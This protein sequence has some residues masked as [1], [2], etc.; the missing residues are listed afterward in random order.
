MGRDKLA[1]SKRAK[2]KEKLANKTEKNK[3]LLHYNLRLFIAGDEPNSKMAEKTL[4]D[5]CEKYLHGSYKLEIIDVTKDFNISIEEKVFFAPTL[6]IETPEFKS[7]IVGS[8]NDVQKLLE[9]LG[10]FET[11]GNK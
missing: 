11:G 8:L 4:K 2:K 6:I 1:D 3:N 5:I 7:R 10:L 9:L